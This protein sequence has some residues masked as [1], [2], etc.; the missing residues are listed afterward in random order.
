MASR[1]RRLSAQQIQDLLDESDSSFIDSD[2]DGSS[3]S[4]NGVDSD[5]SGGSNETLYYV[6]DDDLIWSPTATQRARLPFTGA[7]GLKKVVADK[8]D[9][10]QYFELLVTQDMIDSI[11]TETNRRGLQLSSQPNL[12]AR[13]RMRQWR[14]VDDAEIRV[15]IAILLYQGIVQK[16]ENDMFWTTKPLLETPY[17]RKIMSELRFTLILKCLHFVDND[18]IVRSD[19]PAENSFMKIKCFHEALVANFSTTYIPT[20]NIAID[21]SLMLWKGRLDMKQYIPLKRARWGLKS[22]ELCESGSGY[23]WKSMIHIGTAMEL[24]QSVDG[25]VSSR[26][27]LTLAQELLGKGYCIFM[28]NWYS[29]PALYREL[30]SNGTDAVGTVRLNRKNMPPTLKAKIARGQTT[31]AFTNDMMALKW[32]DKKEVTMLSTFHGAQMQTV[33]VHR[34]EKEKPEAVI[35]YNQNMGAVDVGDQMLVAYPSERKRHKIWYKKHFRHLLNQAV[36]NSYILFSKE[37]SN[38]K[39]T[40][41]EFRIQLIEKLLEVYHH[42]HQIPRRGRPSSLQTNPLRLTGRHFLK[43]VPANEGKDAPTRRCKV[44][45]S[46]VDQ[47]GK[48]IRKETRYYCSD[49]DV[50]LC[51]VPCFESYHTKTNF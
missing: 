13:S 6:K 9:P 36:L 27:V 20:E 10:L 18:T 3:D 22:Y 42:P 11:V 32:M 12:K 14:E 33:T 2:E 37:I 40:H 16:P 29:S 28:D 7:P 8:G 47:N 5:D 41:L 34:G 19:S 45:C 50:A 39:T 51:V 48:K 44:C 25:L 43:L 17:I 24:V 15:F 23:I 1:K 49:C 21:E 4:S 35:L 31:A 30:H 26:I 46:H 38:A